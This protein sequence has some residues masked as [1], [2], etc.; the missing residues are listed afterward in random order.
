VK[1]CFLIEDEIEH[2]QI[3][4]FSIG[5]DSIRPRGTKRSYT[6]LRDR[7]RENECVSVNVCV[8]ACVHEIRRDNV[9]VCIRKSER[10]RQCVFVCLPVY[11][12]VH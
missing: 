6:F 5:L 10:D 1:T 12:C 2:K 9:C 8:D 7:E 4:H 11:T 3:I